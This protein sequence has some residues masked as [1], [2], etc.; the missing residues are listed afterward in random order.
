MFNLENEIKNWL[1]ELRKNPGFEDGDIAEMEDHLRE[2]IDHNLDY[3]LTPSAAFSKATSSFGPLDTTSGEII[4]SRTAEMKIPKTD[5]LAHNYARTTN[6][7]MSTSIMFSNY[8]KIAARNVRKQKLFSFINILS[9]TIGLT[10]TLLIF[11][12]VH[13]E[14]AF[15]Q[16]NTDKD[17]IYRVLQVQNNV[18]GSLDYKGTSHA[19]SLGPEIVSNI[20]VLLLLRGFLNTGRMMNITFG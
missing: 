18:D 14:L 20:P 5:P 10:A 16:F 15:D 6:K 1:R 4:K 12:F 13:D 9:L 7:L 2:V 3:G 17:N 11:L 8:L 19:I